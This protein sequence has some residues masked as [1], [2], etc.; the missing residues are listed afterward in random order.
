M[1]MKDDEKDDEELDQRRVQG[2][3]DHSARVNSLDQMRQIIASDTAENSKPSSN[4]SQGSMGDPNLIKQP[5][6]LY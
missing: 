2:Q 5:Q 6:K 1:V 4:V 3:N